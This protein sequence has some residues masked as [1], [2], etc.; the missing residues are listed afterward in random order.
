[1]MKEKSLEMKKTIEL[2]EQN[3]YERK[4]TKNPIPD[5]LIALEE[6]QAIKEEPIQKME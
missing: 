1:M 3:A 6:K 2:I 4:K 5:A